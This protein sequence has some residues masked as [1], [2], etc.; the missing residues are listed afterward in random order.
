MGGEWAY[1]MGGCV[2][3]WLQRV[4]AEGGAFSRFEGGGWGGEAE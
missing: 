1:S 3:M 2:T 4:Y